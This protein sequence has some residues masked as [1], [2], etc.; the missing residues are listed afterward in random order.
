M[1][2]SGGYLFNLLTEHFDSLPINFDSSG[3]SIAISFPSDEIVFLSN[4]GL[5]TFL[6]QGM[7]GF[8]LSEGNGIAYKSTT[9]PV[10][11]QGIWYFLGVVDQATVVCAMQE[12]DKEVRQVGEIEEPQDFLRQLLMG[13]FSLSRS[14]S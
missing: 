14:N 13:D 1:F 12:E 10:K 7:E 4:S 5:Y 3:F 6:L 2:Y 8:R 11:Q 9:V